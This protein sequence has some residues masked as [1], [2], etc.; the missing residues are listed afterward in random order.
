MGIC[1]GMV[2][3]I[4]ERFRKTAIRRISR[5]CGA[6]FYARAGYRLTGDVT[7]TIMIINLRKRKT[8]TGLNALANQDIRIRIIT[9]AGDAREASSTAGLSNLAA[10][11]PAQPPVGPVVGKTFTVRV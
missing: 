8:G 4:G 9:K 10:R 6:L 7:K 2:R 5:G 1:F 3:G 11:E